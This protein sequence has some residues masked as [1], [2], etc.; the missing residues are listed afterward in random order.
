MGLASPGN[1]PAITVDASATSSPAI[2]LMVTASDF[3]MTSFRITGLQTPGGA[4]K[5]GLSIRAGALFG[6]AG[7]P[8]VSNVRISGN[9]FSNEPGATSDSLDS[10]AISLGMEPTAT[11]AVLANVA[12]VGNTFAHF[13]N[14]SDAVQVA[15]A[16]TSNTIQDVLVIGN[17]FS[18]I[19]LPVELVV[20]SNGQ[21]SKILRVQ[22]LQNT[23]TDNLKPPAIITHTYMV[24]VAK[25]NEQLLV[26]FPAHMRDAQSRSRR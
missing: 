6:L 1:Q 14:G 18:D 20:A 4:K 8:R 21:N 26:V 3:A 5:F 15:A 16:G 9:V 19:T 12:I 13:Q 17:T 25:V 11:G 7:N 24:A 23:F 10:L 2:V 22:I